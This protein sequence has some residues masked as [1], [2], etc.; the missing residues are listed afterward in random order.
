M[1]L[2]AA[3]ILAAP[4]PVARP[5][6]LL[7]CVGTYAVYNASSTHHLYLC[8]DNRFVCHWGGTITEGTY[9]LTGNVVTLNDTWADRPFPW[10]FTLTPTGGVNVVFLESAT[11]WKVR[12]EGD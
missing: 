6:R 3:L 1:I 4:V 11:D 8:R 9:T 2:A 5:A 7:P 12:R 10:R